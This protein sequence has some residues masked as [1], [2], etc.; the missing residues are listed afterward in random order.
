MQVNQIVVVV[1]FLR[2]GI[3]KCCFFFLKNDFL[4]KFT[5]VSKV[6][7]DSPFLPVLDRRT[8]YE[9]SIV[10]PLSKRN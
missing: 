3:F 5:D 7:D 10:L 1:V 9:N 6:P 2:P 4:V 8:R